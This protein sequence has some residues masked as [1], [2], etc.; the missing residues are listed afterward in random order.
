MDGGGHER[1]ARSGTLNV[2]GIVGMGAAARVL[3][4]AVPEETARIRGLRDRLHDG[5]LDR[6]DGVSLNGPPLGDERHPGNLHVAFDRVSADALLVGLAD[7][8]AAST[9]SACASGTPGPSHVLRA[10]GVAPDRAASSVRFGVGR[11]TT[12]DDIDHA[13]ERL[14]HEVGRLRG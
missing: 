11:F 3:L 14:V 4:D 1:G 2:P 6:L 9:G 12:A 8:L 13:L 7:E 10:C 5:L